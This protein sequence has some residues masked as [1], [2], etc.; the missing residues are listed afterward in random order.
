MFDMVIR[1][2]L[3]RPDAPTART[4]RLASIF[5]VKPFLFG[6]HPNV[7]TAATVGLIVVLIALALALVDRT[8]RVIV[9]IF[10]VNLGVLLAA[11]PYF[12][13][14]AAFTAAPMALVIGLAAGRW[15]AASRRSWLTGSVIGTFLLAVLAAGGEVAQ[16]PMGLR[17]PSAAFSAVAPPGCLVSDDPS[18]LIQ[19][20]RLSHELLSNCHVD[21]DVTGITY[22]RLHEIGPNGQTIKRRFNVAWQHYF[23]SYLLSGSSYVVA[24]KGR[25]GLSAYTLATLRHRPELAAADGLTLR[26]GYGTNAP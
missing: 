19:M 24:R 6:G 12:L 9:A 3:L 11:P 16:T 22:D 21:I 25:D 4:V 26:R 2:Q 18:A 7:A 5:G 23:T 15:I 17:F 10:L 8:A 13:H 20:N 1:D 14:Y